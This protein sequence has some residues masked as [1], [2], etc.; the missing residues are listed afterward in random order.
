MEMKATKSKRGAMHDGHKQAQQKGV[1]F[2]VPC[3]P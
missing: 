2:T 3:A 1:G